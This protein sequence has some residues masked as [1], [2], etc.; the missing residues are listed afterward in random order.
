[1]SSSLKALARGVPLVC[2]DWGNTKTAYRFL[3]NY[4]VTE[5]NIAGEHFQSTRD[6]FA[7]TDATVLILHDTTEFSCH[8]DDIRA[9][10]ILK[11][12]FTGQYKA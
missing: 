6:R 4:H 9:I 3:S 10:D 11:K 12:S 8:R 5:G 7:A 2:Q 1:L